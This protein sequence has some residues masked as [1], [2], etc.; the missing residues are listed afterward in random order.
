MSSTKEKELTFSQAYI[1]AISGTNAKLKGSILESNNEHG[2][3][4]S[5]DVSKEP[6][7]RTLAL[8]G[9]EYSMETEA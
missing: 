5:V 4:I 3:K 2:D 7:I 8:N 6:P 1:T 9:S